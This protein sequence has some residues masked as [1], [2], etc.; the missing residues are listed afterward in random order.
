MPLTKTTKLWLWILSVPVALLL[1]CIIGLKLYL[2]SDRLK[3]MVIPP[4]EESTH[5]TAAVRSI[6]F[7][8]FPTFNL[9]IDGL[10]ISNPRGSTFDEEKFI[11]FGARLPS[12]LSR[13]D[14]DRLGQVEELPC[15]GPLDRAERPRWDRDFQVARRHRGDGRDTKSGERDSES[16]SS[17]PRY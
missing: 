10:S 2:T 14:E 6:S 4:I 5:R 9:T 13:L 15:D 7:S 16:R 3:S 11:S 8:V 17:H 1:L 12:G